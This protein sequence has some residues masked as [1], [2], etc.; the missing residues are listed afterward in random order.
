MISSSEIAGTL[1]IGFTIKA[2][3]K[4]KVGGSKIDI[5]GS[6]YTFGSLAYEFYYSGELVDFFP[7][8]ITKK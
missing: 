5:Y 3:S 1:L 8:N 6:K 7:Y 2:K 4:S